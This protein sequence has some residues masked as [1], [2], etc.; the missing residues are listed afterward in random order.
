[1]SE[2]AAVEPDEVVIPFTGELVRRDDPKACATALDD[3]RKMETALKELKGWLTRAVVAESARQGKKTL[4]LDDLT[5]VVQGGYGLEWDVSELLR[6]L[7]LGLPEER[8]NALVTEEITYRVSAAEAK[9]I[10]A[11]NPEY[12]AV[13]E[14]ARSEVPKNHWIKVT[15]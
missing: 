14:R 1:M 11:A 10:A 8:F 2:I 7:D 4:A 5:V 13:I 6:L 9:R 3:I 12:A 15:R